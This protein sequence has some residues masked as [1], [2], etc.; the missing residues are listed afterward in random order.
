MLRSPMLRSTPP[1]LLR[2]PN[3]ELPQMSPHHHLNEL[4]PP[5]AE[6]PPPMMSCPSEELAQC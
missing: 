2:S 4:P 1:P 5:Y 6:L 3:N